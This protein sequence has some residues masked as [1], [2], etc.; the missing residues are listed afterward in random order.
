MDNSNYTSMNILQGVLVV[1]VP[2]VLHGDVISQLQNRLLEKINEVKVNGVVFDFSTLKLIDSY[3]YHELSNVIKMTNMLGAEAVVVGL[4]PG[5]VTAFL[6]LNVE[7][8]YLNP[9]LNLDAGLEYFLSKMDRLETEEIE[10]IANF[11]KDYEEPESCQ[12]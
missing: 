5:L 10:P 7:T 4:Q 6:D 8:E 12:K 3:E 1:T 11:E 9:F 2:S